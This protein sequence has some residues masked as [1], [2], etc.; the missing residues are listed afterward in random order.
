MSMLD[1]E[2]CALHTCRALSFLPIA[3]SACGARFCEQHAAP[4]RHACKAAAPARTAQDA[5][6]ETR[7]VC[8]KAGCAKP[9][10]QVARAGAVT[11]RAPRCERCGGLFCPAHRSA[12]AH[13]CQVPRPPTEG[14][15]RA[16]AAEARRA[17]ARA[18]LAK[19]FG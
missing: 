14:E 2:H 16:A 17:R 3:C 10:L 11:H 6:H 5:S 13:A 15:R 18:V 4:E 9:T 12:A 7:V 19:Q 1:G 8:H